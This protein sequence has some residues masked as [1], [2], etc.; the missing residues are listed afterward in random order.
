M[1]E[2]PVLIDITTIGPNPYQMRQIED[3]LVVAELAENI[4]RNTLLQPPTVRPADTPYDMTYELAFGHTRLAAFKL[5]ASQGKVE[6]GQIP[7]FVK[8]LDDLQMFEMA[9]AENIKRRNLNPVETGAAMQTY[10][11][12]FGK[13]SAETG[14][15]FNV[16]EATVRGTV[17]LLKLPEA[18]K[19]KLAAGEITMGAARQLLVLVRVAPDSI[20]GAVESIIEGSQPE[21]VVENILDGLVYKNK[22]IKMWA[23]WHSGKPHAGSGLWELTATEK[24][25]AKYMPP[26]AG[27]EGLDKRLAKKLLESV[28][29]VAHQQENEPSTTTMIESW[30]RKLQGGLVAA[31]ALIAQGAPADAIER[32]DQLVHPPA[33]TACPF[34]VK[35]NNNH[36]CTWKVCHSRKMQA[37]GFTELDKEEKKLEIRGLSVDEARGGFVVFGTTYSSDEDR[38]RE[39]LIAS[40]DPNLRLHIK[41]GQY[42]HPFTKSEIVEVVTIAPKA[43]EE[44]KAKEKKEAEKK[45]QEESARKGMLAGSGKLH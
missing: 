22:A 7:C 5:L 39:A 32:L 30:A 31:D 41:P 28:G 16:D 40:K 20:E 23:S 1:N 42:E 17:R 36:Y 13:T 9:V 43:V 26:V 15:F 6:F 27:L 12:Q 29:L 3:P 19:A 21:K 8:Y 18:A 37:W 34:Y 11:E 24:V 38:K 33:C 2:A 44:K 35:A 10:M 14:E 25:F 4:A 45:K